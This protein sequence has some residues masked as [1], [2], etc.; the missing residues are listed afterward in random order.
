MTVSNVDLRLIVPFKTFMPVV[1]AKTRWRSLWCFL[2]FI[3]C[4]FVVAQAQAQAKSTTASYHVFGRCH[5][6]ATALGL[7]ASLVAVTQ[8]GRSKLAECQPSGDFDVLLPTSATHLTIEMKGYQPV[9]IPVHFTTDI[10]P[11]ARFNIGNLTAMAKIGSPPIPPD[12]G[13]LLALFFSMPDSLT[14]K[15]HL[16]SLTKPSSHL[17]ATIAYKSPISRSFPIAPDDYITTISTLDNRLFLSE[18]M[19]VRPGAT[20]KAVKAM[21]PAEVSTLNEAAP[22][23]YTATELALSI[24]I[25][26]FDQSSHI[27]RP[28]VKVALDSLAHRLVKQPNLV[29][30]V[31]GYTDNVGK[32]ELNLVLAEY[33]AKAVENYLK[34]RGV[35]ANQIKAS[36]EGPDTKASAEASEAVKTISRRVVIQLSPR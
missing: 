13:A 25:L 33:R 27:L 36:W 1:S 11:K 8:Q 7:K 10:P 4:L 21:K 18:K 6:Y 32:R 5:D 24:N 2:G 26:Y 22:N 19:T 29:A 9:T 17:Q 30:T 12:K 15:Y 20:F 16:T 14:I 28:G 34:E 3:A 35:P 31:T 23:T